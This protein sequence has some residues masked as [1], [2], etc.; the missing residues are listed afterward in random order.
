LP[1]TVKILRAIEE[2]TG[3]PDDLRRLELHTRLLGPGKTFC[4]L[5]PGAMEPLQSGLQYFR[6]VFEQHVNN[7]SCP[8][9]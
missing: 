5:A 7:K 8:W 9:R 6:D 2:G 1:W 3:I 4:A